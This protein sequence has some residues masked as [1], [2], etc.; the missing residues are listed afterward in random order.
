MPGTDEILASENCWRTRMGI[1][2]PRE[3]RVI[4]RGRDLFAELGH[5]PW[6]ALLLYGITGR[7][8]DPKQIRLFEGIWSLCTSY[9]DPRLWNNRVAALA[10]TSRSTAALGVA[11]ATAVSEASIYGRRPDIRAVD[12]LYRAKEKVDQGAPLEEIIKNELKRYRTLPGFGRPITRR[13]ERISVLLALAKDLGLADGPYV[14]LAFR[15]QESL[16]NSRLRMQMNVAAL[17]AALAADQ[18]LS[19]RETYHYTLL[20]FSV[21]LV[22]CY[23]GAFENPEGTFFPLRCSTVSYR[24]S[25]ARTWAS[26]KPG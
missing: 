24:G 14:A 13:D 11:A 6:M 2:L 21:G 9:P 5:L 15:I 25:P 22:A 8:L 18:G 12:F 16:A 17:G 20:S 3:G 4:F 7:I 19:P 1:W 23:L 26:R 10:G